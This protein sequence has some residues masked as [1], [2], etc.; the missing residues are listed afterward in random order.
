MSTAVQLFDFRGH[1]VRAV[2]ID[3]QP[4]M[5]GRDVAAGLGFANGSRDVARHTSERQRRG[6]RIGTPGGEQEVVLANEAGLYRM[7]M[8]ANTERAIEFQDW[9][10]EEV[11]PAIRK[12]GTYSVAPA[13]PVSYAHALR[14]LA[15]EVE[16]REQVEQQVAVLEPSAK[17]WDHLASAAGDLSVNETAK[18][19]SRSGDVVIGER[20][21]FTLLADWGW[22]YRDAEREWRPYQAQVDTG[23]LATRARS[24]HH[25]RTGEL[26]LDAPQLRV[27]PKGMAEI[28]RRL[29]PPRQQ[30]AIDAGQ[31][32][33][34]DGGRVAL[35]VCGPLLAAIL[36][37]S[38]PGLG[39]LLAGVLAVVAVYH[40]SCWVDRQEPMVD[41]VWREHVEAEARLRVERERAIAAATRIPRQRTGVRA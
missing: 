37:R 19:I 12:T 13:L 24:H 28:H 26:V 5:V 31:L 9:L 6:Y 32:R 23:R 3:D 21:L 7:A 14:E 1:E 16:R 41:R 29:A 17:A 34:T 20:R 15:A 39:V 4:W 22:I 33:I 10:A 11:L 35:W 38:A 2:V 18:T 27:T 30:L 40:L 25:P 36:I 8:R